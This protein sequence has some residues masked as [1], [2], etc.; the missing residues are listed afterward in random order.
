LI[1]TKTGHCNPQQNPTNNNGNKFQSKMQKTVA[2]TQS[3]DS[4]GLR[5]LDSSYWFFIQR[6]ELSSDM[7]RVLFTEP[8]APAVVFFTAFTAP[9]VVFFT[10]STAPE[11][12]LMTLSPVYNAGKLITYETNKIF[13]KLEG[14]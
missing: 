9:A 14:K 7:P 11:A 2:E 8:T 1:K 12:A 3:N 10:A 6:L 4:L 13:S 5:P